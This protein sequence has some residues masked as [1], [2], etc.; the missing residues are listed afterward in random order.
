MGSCFGRHAWV[1]RGRFRID[2]WHALPDAPNTL[3]VLRNQTAPGAEFPQVHRPWL[4]W[5]HNG[6]PKPMTRT[7]CRSLKVWASVAASLFFLIL[8]V[9]AKA[10][11]TGDE[12]EEWLKWDANAKAVYVLA[13]VQGLQKG[14]SKGC[15]AG[16]STIQARLKYDDAV[17]AHHE[18]WN[19]FPISTRDS[20]QLIDSITMFYTAYPK[21]RFLYISD[22]LLE[23]HVGRS[24]EQIHGHF[25]TGQ[26]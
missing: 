20:A 21:Q 22:I 4:D 24:I 8:T 9:Q 3:Q 7:Y 14:Y 1:R 12:G 23:L 15:E 17:R 11:W 10:A 26:K 6:V 25:P 13:Y 19:R 2:E 5:I 16:I 18:C